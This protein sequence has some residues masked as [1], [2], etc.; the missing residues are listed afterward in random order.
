[1]K[2]INYAE[3]QIAFALKQAELGMPISDVSRKFGIAEQTFWY[4]RR[5][6]GRM[7]LSVHITRSFE[8]KDILCCP[9]L[10]PTLRYSRD[11]I[12]S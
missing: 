10:A 6:Q 3:E 1:M 8:I 7:I 9:L 11:C 4:W 5:K 12:T 2:A